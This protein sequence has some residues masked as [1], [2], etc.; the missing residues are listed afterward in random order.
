MNRH[1]WITGGLTHV[2][3]YATGHFLS[4]SRRYY[5]DGSSLVASID[6]ASDYSRMLLR[7]SV[8]SEFDWEISS[9]DGVSRSH[10]HVTKGKSPSLREA[11]EECSKL[12]RG[13]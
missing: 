2:D 9:W 3:W 6:G 10:K 5:P 4:S 1:A 8:L 12:L 7:R 11:K 13:R